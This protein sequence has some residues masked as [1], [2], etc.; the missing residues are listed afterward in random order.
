MSKKEN[1]KTVEYVL[2]NSINFFENNPKSFSSKQFNRLLKSVK[3]E[4]ILQPLFVNKIS[5]TV[6]DGN[7]RLKVAMQLALETVPVIFLNIEKKDEGRIV[8]IFNNTQMEKDP[9][10]MFNLLK[11]YDTDPLIMDYLKD[12]A[13]KVKNSLEGITSEFSIVREVDESYDYIV[14]VTKKSVDFL[15]LQT[16]FSLDNVY[17]Q[18]KNKVIGL[19]RVVDADILA[20][21]VDLALKNGIKNIDE[22]L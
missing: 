12:Y 3:V 9:D 16:F 15:Q 13:E 20:K 18:Y 10:A 5:N 4:G 22:L 6:L 21:L 8:A 19:G 11:K 7:Q 2:T 1:P 17:D 14:F